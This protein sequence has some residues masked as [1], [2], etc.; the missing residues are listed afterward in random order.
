MM[1]NVGKKIKV[2][3]YVE[4]EE[5]VVKERITSISTRPETREMDITV[6]FSNE[7]NES[8]S[9]QTISLS[10]DN[11]DL[12]FSE[13]SFFDVGKQLGSYRESDLWKMIDKV[14]NQ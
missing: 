7:K 2:N 13:E 6:A 14:S 5:T 4:I 11:Y 1:R 3:K 9:E 8:V 12:L 10:G